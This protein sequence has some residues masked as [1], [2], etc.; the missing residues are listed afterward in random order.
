MGGGGEFDVHCDPLS[1]SIKHGLQTADYGLRTGYKICTRYK[2]A[3]W[4]IR[5]GY[6]TRTRYKTRTAGFGLSIKYKFLVEVL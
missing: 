5:T 4:K 6:K 2:N 1:V 3:D